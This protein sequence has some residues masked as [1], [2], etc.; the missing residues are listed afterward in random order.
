MRI[1]KILILLLGLGVV[2][3]GCSI[4]PKQL[5]E[6]QITDSSSK[7]YKKLGSE[8]KE[9]KDP[10]S[11][12][13]AIA[14]SIKYN[15][16]QRL[17]LM[18]VSLSKKDIENVSFD[19]LP[20]LTANAGYTGRDKDSSSYSQVVDGNLS[21][22]P[23]YSSEKNVTTADLTMS[24]NVLDFGLSYVRAKQAADKY[25]MAQEEKRKVI[26][27]IV[28]EVISAYYKALAAEKLLSRVEKV[29]ARVELALKDSKKIGQLRYKSPIDALT[30]QKD[31]MD[32]LK[33][34]QALERDLR[35]AKGE[36]AALMGLRPGQ[37]FELKD[38]DI[39]NQKFNM[40]NF[41]L[42][43]MELTAL[44]KRPE[45]IQSMYQSRITAKEVK[46]NMLGLLPG[47]RLYAGANYSSNNYLVHD[48]WA[49]YG[50][51]ASWNLFNVFKIGNINDMNKLKEALEKQ[52]QLAMSMAV[53]TQLHI[54]NADYLL[55]IKEFKLADDYF[56]II[57]ELYKHVQAGSKVGKVGNLRLI[58][59]ELR[60]LLALLKRDLTYSELQNNVIKMYISMGLDPVPFNANENSIKDLS[61]AIE[62]QLDNWK[63]GKVKLMASDMKNKTMLVSSSFEKTYKPAEKQPVNKVV[64]KD[65]PAAEVKK[66][67]PVKVKKEVK[68][69]PKAEKPE[70]ISK[71]KN[72]AVFA[73]PEDLMAGWINSWK[74]MDYDAYMKFY[75]KSFVSNKGLNYNEWAKFRKSRLD[76]KGQ[77]VIEY[78]EI[79]SQQLSNDIVNTAAIMSYEFNGK[80]HSFV[81]VLKWEKT[82][83]GWKIIGEN[84]Y[85]NLAMIKYVLKFAVV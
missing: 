48:N 4:K 63:N 42:E 24:W 16:E 73:N 36:L 60:Y 84:S 69:Q 38:K 57:S 46:A 75:G 40:L 23:S 61:K 34:I 32:I 30:Y 13:E 2:L 27:N 10:V 76:R 82:E 80:K 52:Q 11:I 3:V 67:E 53:L 58:K 8:Q 50:A 17:Q 26:Q 9:L 7:I 35:G 43:D 20:K 22:S 49:Q 44:T 6:K 33:S 64:K 28:K 1:S 62:K 70:V 25:L 51:S 41:A 31:L 29:T 5:S 15:H 74:S 56:G 19:M 77:V 78:N 83:G 59:E 39:L 45:L 54:A 65:K 81:K 21:A 47:I 14:R 37:P 66:A 12:Y 55:G 71:T 18:R 68:V 79:K 72:S 85:S